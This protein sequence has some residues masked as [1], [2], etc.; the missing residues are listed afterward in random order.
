MGWLIGIVLTMI[1]VAIGLLVIAKIPG[2]G[3]EVDSLSIAVISA[4]VFGVLNG[5]LGWLGA[6][7]KMTF[8]LTPL[9][10]VLNIVIFGLT[11]WLVQGFRLRNGWISAA[12]GALAL[13][14]ITQLINFAIGPQG[15]GL[16]TAALSG[17]NVG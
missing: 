14:L 13:A 8:I 16:T 17:L 11:A 3:V 7:F 5:V 6:L 4:L 15:L 10:W 9:A 1:V 2:L 12:L